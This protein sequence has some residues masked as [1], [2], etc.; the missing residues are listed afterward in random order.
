MKFRVK[1]DVKIRMIG[2]DW[3]L[4]FLKKPRKWQELNDFEKKLWKNVFDEKLKELTRLHGSTL[5]MY[6]VAKQYADNELKKYK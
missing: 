3:V 6:K 4:H 1:K 5:E 2:V